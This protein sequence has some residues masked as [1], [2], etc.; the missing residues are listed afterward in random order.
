MFRW[1]A[2]NR[3]PPTPASTARNRFIRSPR[4]SRRSV[5]RPDPGRRRTERRRRA[6]VPARLQAPR[7]AR[8][9]HD[10][11]RSPDAR[12]AASLHDRRQSIGRGRQMG[13]S[14]AGGAAASVGQRRSGFRHE[15]IGF[16]MGE[17]D[18]RIESLS[19]KDAGAAEPPIPVVAGLP[20]AGSGTPGGWVGT[21]SYAATPA[22]R[23]RMPR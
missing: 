15:A 17:I 23:P 4:A 8:G 9:P 13:R 20:S 22:I 5:Q 3:I 11:A 14:A 7:L 16:N 18:L 2:S 10:P 6:R 12:A 19:S 1:S 21:S